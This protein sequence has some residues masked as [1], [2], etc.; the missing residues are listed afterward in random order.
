[1]NPI[2]PPP[3][4]PPLSTLKICVLGLERE[5]CKRDKRGEKHLYPHATPSE[6]LKATY[7]RAS[8]KPDHASRGTNSRRVLN[9]PK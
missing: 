4:C 9:A 2:T 1:M 8:K 6:P 7:Q 5:E 3:R